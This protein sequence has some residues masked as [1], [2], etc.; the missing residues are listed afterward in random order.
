M[1]YRF[2]YHCV[3]VRYKIP[4]HVTFLIYPCQFIY[5]PLCLPVDS[6]YTYQ[7]CVL[8][9]HYILTICK[10]LV[11]YI[12]G[13]ITIQTQGTIQLSGSYTWSCSVVLIR[14]LGIPHMLRSQTILC[15]GSTL[16]RIEPV[17]S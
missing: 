2:I 14:H 17:K 13:T 15:I 4:D 9:I 12:T 3:T 7:L 16:G 8:G 6:G 5:M 11:D 10:E 1:V